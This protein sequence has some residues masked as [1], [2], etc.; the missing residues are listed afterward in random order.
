MIL[1]VD[2][3][4]D[5]ASLIKISLEKAGFF[6]SAFTDPIAALEEFRSYPAD[7]DLLISDIRMPGMNGYELVQ[8]VKKIKPDV[9]ILL[10][11][12]FEYNSS[13][14][15]ASGHSHLDIAGFIEK[16]VRMRELCTVVFTILDSKSLQYTPHVHL[17]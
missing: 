2:D 8:Q 14:Y 13:K 11:S 15:F 16:P 6:I 10:M 5:I 7:F 12:A 4:Y 17:L 9:K 1:I 3:K